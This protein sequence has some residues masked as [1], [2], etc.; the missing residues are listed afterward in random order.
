LSRSGLL[1][2]ALLAAPEVRSDVKAQASPDSSRPPRTADELIQQFRAA[3]EAHS[4][5]NIARLIYWG[6]AEEYMQRATE[7]Q[8]VHDF[9]LTIA[10]VTIQL[11]SADEVPEYDNDARTYRPPIPA[12]RRM[13]VEF[14]PGSTA[15]GGVASRSYLVGVKK[16]TFYLVSTVPVRG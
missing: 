6:G 1:A 2:L 14:L 7:R 5:A 8:I 3:H 10:R 12:T 4:V 13:T 11:L 15:S 16:G 9:P